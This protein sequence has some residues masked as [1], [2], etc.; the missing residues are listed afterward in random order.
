[1]AGQPVQIT[2]PQA[3][4]GQPLVIEF[5]IDRSALPVGADETTLQVFRDGT[6]AGACTGA[7]ATPDPCVAARSSAP[8]GP[9]WV[10][11]TLTVRT[12]HASG[13]MTARH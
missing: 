2:A 7:G 5:S 9:G 3:T 12:S 11:L 13:W 4:A 8:A 10:Y 1:M 6:Q